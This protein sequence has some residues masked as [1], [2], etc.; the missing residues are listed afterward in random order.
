MENG[1]V[2][3]K[4]KYGETFE[5][6]AGKSAMV[7]LLE[8][9]RRLTLTYAQFHQAILQIKG[10]LDSAALSDFDRIAVLSPLT[11][12]AA[13]VNVALPYLGYTAVPLD[14][15]LPAEEITGEIRRQIVEMKR[16]WEK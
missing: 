13:V 5:K 16:G 9:G 7:Y 14:I 4:K 2:E 15:S 6:Y 8:D 1:H 11:P 3:Y 10:L 12:F